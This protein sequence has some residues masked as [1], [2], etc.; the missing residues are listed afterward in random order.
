VVENDALSFE[1]D[2]QPSPSKARAF[3][4]KASQ[5]IAN[6]LVIGL[7]AGLISDRWPRATGEMT[8]LSFAQSLGLERPHR[9]FAR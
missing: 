6:E 1:Q 2:L 7:F 5:P 3:L 9:F 8:R 4:R